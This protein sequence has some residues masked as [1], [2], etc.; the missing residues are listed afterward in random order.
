MLKIK[1]LQASV[2]LIGIVLSSELAIM[3]LIDSSHLRS[4]LSPEMISV[5][6]AV[7]L[8]L[9]AAGA[10]YWLLVLPLRNSIRKNSQLASAIAHTSMGYI[11]Y[12]PYLSGGTFLFSNEAFKS[13]TGFDLEDIRGKSF[14]D[15]LDG[16]QLKA[17]T[18]AVKAENKLS[19][20]L[21]FPCKDN[22]TFWAELKLIPIFDE[23]GL[24]N[25]YVI[26]IHDATDK[27]LSG[28]DERKMLRAIEQSSESVIITD[29]K[30]VIEYVNP[31]F[32]KTTGYKVDEVI[33]KTPAILSSGD[34][35]REWYESLWATIMEGKAWSGNH[36]NRRKDGSEYNEFMTIS[37][38]RDDDGRITHFVSVQRD[39]SEQT[40]LENKLRRAQKLEAVGTLAGGIAHDFNNALAGILGHAYLLKDD[41]D[42]EK[43]HARIE[44]IEALGLKSAEIVKQLLSFSR[45]Q[46][47]EKKAVSLIPFIKE[48]AKFFEASI[49]DNISFSLDITQADDLTVEMDVVQLQQVIMNI[50][51][52]ARDSLKEKGQGSICLSVVK[53]R[54]SDVQNHIISNL[55]ISPNDE[56][57]VLSIQDDG[58]G[59]SNEDMD[60]I[61]DPFFSTKALD[62]G[63]GLG[64]AMSYG[65][66]N[67]HHG[68]IHVD[69]VVDRGTRF[70]IYLPTVSKSAQTEEIDLSTISLNGIGR[71]ILIVDDNV[72]VRLSIVEIMEGMG[73][74]V[75]QAADGYQAIDMY[76]RHW[77]KIDIILM[78]IVMPNLGGIAAAKKIRESDSGIPILFL[79]AYDPNDSMADIS[80]MP[81]VDL[82]TK[83]YDPLTLNRKVAQ[84]LSY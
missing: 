6:D 9:I 22:S 30:G 53:K 44:T 24:L 59:I 54:C 26:L 10:A 21:Q 5:I 49:P 68:Y 74:K 19:I 20:E 1:P 60:K 65:I 41:V 48:T 17:I 80:W 39:V 47:S 25:Q 8:T 67:Q 46:E 79:T 18:Q 35:D 34:K 52:N 13:Q 38:I 15:F 69:S 40:T 3:Y 33:G 77:A 82:V 31:A 56:V 62:Q 71:T 4:I 36:I 70:E 72:C 75:L 55:N 11:S 50:I 64:L 42:N 61:F 81:K 83:P 28:L 7:F 57:C 51:N 73:F 63:T 76:Q 84:L 37:P 58:C 66:I 16:D 2:I 27:R 14:S 12:D 45:N 29:I 43:A 78:D 23:N 32:E